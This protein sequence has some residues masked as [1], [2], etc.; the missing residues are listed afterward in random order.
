VKKEFISCTELRNNAIKL[1]YTIYNTIGI[2]DIIYVLLRGGA[3][4]GNILSEYFKILNKGKRPVYYAAVVA[5]SYRDLHSRE[6]VKVD[7]W[8]YSPEYLRQGD[9]VLLVDD[10]FDTGVT[11]NHLVEII[12]RNGIHRSEIKIAVHDYK[13]RTYVTPA[14][15]IVPDFFCR[16]LTVNAPEDDVWI[17]YLTHELQNLTNE[18]LKNCDFKEDETML[19]ALELLKIKGFKA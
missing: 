13:E 12:M 19:Q 16:K 6:Q 2:P 1:A 4:L 8:T 5:R 15:T 7:G 18:E 14:P 17:H 3:L 9:T 11:V 10:I